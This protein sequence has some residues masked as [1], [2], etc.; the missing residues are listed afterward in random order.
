M[1]E[2]HIKHLPSSRTS[3]KFSGTVIK[4][5]NSL[6]SWFLFNNPSFFIWFSRLIIWKKTKNQRHEE[7]WK[8]DWRLLLSELMPAPSLC[9][10][11]SICWIYLLCKSLFVNPYWI[12]HHWWQWILEAYEQLYAAFLPEDRIW[13]QLNYTYICYFSWK[14]TVSWTIWVVM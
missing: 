3:S 8:I 7:F 10:I 12:G 5:Q 9:C 6:I 1:W 4:S 11:C 13:K 2:L 14:F